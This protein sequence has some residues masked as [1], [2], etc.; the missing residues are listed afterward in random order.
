M[1][2]ELS[3]ELDDVKLIV[4]LIKYS[5]PTSFFSSTLRDKIIHQTDLQLED[6]ILIK[7]SAVQNIDGDIT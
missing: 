2:V 3:L 7:K 5:D 4:A 6:N 1:K